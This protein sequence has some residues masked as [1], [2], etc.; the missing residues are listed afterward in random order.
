MVKKLAPIAAASF[1]A[2]K[3][4][5]DKLRVTLQKRYSGKRE[6]APE[7]KLNF[8]HYGVYVHARANACKYNNISLM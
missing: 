7:K 3:I 8:I 2:G 5:F 6:K 1:F 4:P